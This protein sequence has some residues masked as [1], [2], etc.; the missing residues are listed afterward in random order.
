MQSNA[1]PRCLQNTQRASTRL[2]TYSNTPTLTPSVAP[3]HVSSSNTNKKANR[4]SYI[5]AAP[6]VASTDTTTTTET[7]TADPRSKEIRSWRD[8]FNRLEDKR[9]SQQRYV[10][11]QEQGENMSKL[12]LGAKLDRA[13]QRRMTG[14]DATFSRDRA[15]SRAKELEV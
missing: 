1:D 3:T 12:A 10:V 6:S 13:L 7:Q 2:S 9:L 8:S 14:Q 5:S 15:N 4:A 11:S